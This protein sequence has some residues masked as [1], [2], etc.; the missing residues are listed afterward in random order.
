MVYINSTKLVEPSREEQL[1][2]A[3]LL[4]WIPRW[5]DDMYNR[6]YISKDGRRIAFVEKYADFFSLLETM[7]KLRIECNSQLSDDLKKSFDAE[8]M[9]VKD[10][11]A[12]KAVI[13]KLEALESDA[14]ST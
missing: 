8:M 11:E 4:G 13:H 3:V 2:K 1:K 6:A 14:A 10:N 7:I 12:V 9:L 5:I